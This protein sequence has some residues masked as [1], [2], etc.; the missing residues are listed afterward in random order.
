MVSSYTFTLKPE[1]QSSFYRIELLVVLLHLLTF[2]ILAVSRFPENIAVLCVG[3]AVVIVYYL[4]VFTRKSKSKQSNLILVP[5]IVFVLWWF[6]SGVYWMGVLVLIFSVF[7]V[8]SKQKM[9][10]DFSATA[11][12]FKSF[13]PKTIN[14]ADLNNVVLKDGLLTIDFKNDKLIQQLVEEDKANE[15]AFNSFCQKQLK[16]A[17]VQNL[18]SSNS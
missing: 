3:I 6:Y 14:W 17:A 13:S 9:Q 5:L 1:K 2:I 8:L 12:L 10:V 7:A 11:I 16:A 15:T 4:Y 18:P